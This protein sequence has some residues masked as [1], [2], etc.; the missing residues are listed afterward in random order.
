M[1][2]T[3]EIIGG[4]ADALRLV[5]P[6]L[7]VGIAPFAWMYRLF[8]GGKPAQAATVA[9]CWLFSAIV[10]VVAV[11]RRMP[12]AIPLGV[13]LAWLVILAFVFYDW[14]SKVFV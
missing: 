7:F 9:V 8:A 3:L 6:V 5:L 13:F 2:R 4:I 10:F 12:A 1:K 14:I 11:R